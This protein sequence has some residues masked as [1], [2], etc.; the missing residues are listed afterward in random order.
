MLSALKVRQI[1]DPFLFSRPNP[2]RHKKCVSGMA[3]ESNGEGE[4]EGE[5]NYLLKC[6]CR[7]IYGN[8]NCC[9]DIC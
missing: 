2:V 5:I 9:S 7:Y 1:S 6:W 4:C 8:M 3:L